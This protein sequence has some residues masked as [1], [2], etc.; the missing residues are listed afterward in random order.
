MTT[1][2]ASALLFVIT[3][4]GCTGVTTARGQRLSITSEE[5]RTYAE[6][7]F[8]DQ[9]Q[10]VTE[11]VFAMDGEDLSDEDLQALEGV[12]Q[13]L[14]VECA[15]L[16]EV[17]ARRRDGQQAGWLRESKAARGAPLCERATLNARSVLERLAR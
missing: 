5:F 6:A 8:R 11:I 15:D 7:V 2:R 13:S 3:A 12:E 1:V 4:A 16:N 14:L 10:A 9:N 17:A